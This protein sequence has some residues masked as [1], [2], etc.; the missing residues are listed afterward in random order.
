MTS[1]LNPGSDPGQVAVPS[2]DS[3]SNS[4]IQDVIGNKTDTHSGNSVYSLLK[5]NDEHIHKGQQCYPSLGDAITVTADASGWTY[6]PYVEIIPASTITDYFDIHF[7]NITQI[8]AV[9]EYQLD[10]ATGG[11]GS[12]V[13]Q[14]CVSFERSTNFSQEGSQSIQTPVL[15]AN[16]RVAVRLACKSTNARTVNIKLEYHTY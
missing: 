3:A 16:S 14:A 15:A 12:E 2:A 5:L 10:I 13:S 9:D 8:S 11:A 6:G 1:L 4:Y 7:V